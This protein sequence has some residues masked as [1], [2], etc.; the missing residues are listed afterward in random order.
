[1][2]IQRR[3]SDTFIENKLPDGSRVLI[4]PENESVFALNTTAGA[5]WDACQT[6]TTL[7][8]VVAEMQHSL[9]STVT[10][11]IAEEAIMRLGEQQLLKTTGGP[12]SLPSRRHFIAQI[13]MVALPLVV[14]MT[15]AEQRAYAQNAQSFTPKPQ[16]I[17]LTN[18]WDDPLHN[19][20]H[21]DHDHWSGFDFDP[22]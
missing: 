13:G 12:S 15:T 11:E 3:D 17:K 10:Q 19:H 2:N 9:S 14:A 16:D 22:H 18:T 20:N 8:R 7:P 4:D 21:H 1:M 5:A 6:P